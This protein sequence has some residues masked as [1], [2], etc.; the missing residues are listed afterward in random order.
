MTLR[1][2][3]TKT[4][5]NTSTDRLLAEF[6]I[7][8]LSRSKT[9]DRGV[10]FF[11]SRWLKLAA[12]GLTELA[13]NNGRARIIASPKLSPEDVAAMSQGDIARRDATLRTSLQLTIDELQGEIETNTLSALAWMIAD[14]LLDFRLAI[15]S[16]DLDGDF[17][18]K[19][20]TFGD[21]QHAIAFRGSPNDSAQAFRNYETIS[22]FYSWLDEREALRVMDEQARFDKL[23]ENND[24]NLRIYELPMAI[25]KNLIEFTRHVP[26]P[27]KT[28]ESAAS[29]EDR[30][31][32]HQKLA[33]S[34]FLGAHQGVL[35]MATGTGKTRTAIKI[36]D[37]LRER[38]LVDGA[39]V[40]AHGTDLLDQWY[41]EL[42][43]RTD[44]P[45]Y[46]EYGGH[47]EA[48]TFTNHPKDAVLVMSRQNLSRV[49]PLLSSDLKPKI[50]LICDEVHGMGSASIVAALTGRLDDFEF[51]LGLSATPERA[52]DN[53][54]NEF[55]DREIGPTIF[56][57]PIEDAIQKGILCEF[58]YV[59]LEYNFSDEDK[60]RVRQA[61]KRHHARAR[62]PEPSPVEQLYQELARIRKLSV[63]KIHPFAEYVRSR[64]S[65]LGRCLIFVETAEYGVLVQD[66]LMRFGIDYHTYYGDDDRSNLKRFASGQLECLVTCK[67]ISE[68][69]DIR[70]VNSIVLFASSRARLET[71]QRLGRCL[72]SDPSNPQKRATVI[73]FIRVDDLD[74]E[75]TDDESTADG[76]RRD[77]FEKLA[78][79]RR[80]PELE[81]TR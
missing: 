68:G 21:G 47:R 11:T 76:E 39:I 62:S 3:P 51:R 26:R 16:S 18:D 9:Y 35:E 78:S 30:R 60:A 25:R 14:G 12:S 10:G 59:G 77:W 6:V 63:E 73:D 71:V 2:L 54:G 49:V 65:V 44:L 23:W 41:T 17:H 1:E 56:R 50:L 48:L 33:L 29:S 57:F 75:E 32:Q 34:A 38:G 8:A 4:S 5:Y 31:W 61:I 46:R 67:R 72:R 7:P 13:R 52:Y 22:V 55:I 53:N 24:P 20:G 40:S 81:P 36:L 45:I 70:S 69:I 58:D 15:P 64:P 28:R 27:Y 42:L 37:E 74:E 80:E 66:I 43:K 19:F 79:I